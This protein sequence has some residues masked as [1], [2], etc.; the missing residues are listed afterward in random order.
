M[1]HLV[2][3]KELN[4]AKIN[5]VF[6]AVC[7][8][9]NGNDSMSLADCVRLDLF[10]RRRRRWRYLAECR[11]C[12]CCV[13]PSKWRN[14]SR[15]ETS[16]SITTFLSRIGLKLI[17]IWRN[18]NPS[19]PYKEVA[20]S[21]QEPWSRG[22]GSQLMFWMLWVQIPALF[23][24]WTFSHTFVVKNGMLLEKDWKKQKEAGNGQFLKRN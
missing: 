5:L 20:W 9:E 17:G 8:P 4:K 18:F 1:D 24:E 2:K 6:E 14:G 21:G 13:N 7:N 3:N 11:T 12:F 19:C 10:R 15:V 22:Y 16:T 23:T